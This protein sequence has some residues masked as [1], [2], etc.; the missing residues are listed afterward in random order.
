MNNKLA[1]LTICI[2]LRI[3]F[4]YL[5]KNKKEY[6]TQMA[7][8]A[9]AIAIGF[10]SIYLFKLRE[11]GLEVNGEKIWWDRLRP[12]HGTLYGLFAYY[13]FSGNNMAYKFL[14]ADVVLGLTAHLIHYYS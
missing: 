3:L 7:L 13:T 4:V 9:T 11:T 5:A 12:F 8:V 2:P 6:S 1:F 14:G 10:W